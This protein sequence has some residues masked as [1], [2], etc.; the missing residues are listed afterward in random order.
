MQQIEITKTINILSQDEFIIKRPQFKATL[1]SEIGQKLFDLATNSQT[2]LEL[3]YFSKLTSS[4][5]V[6]AVVEK[7]KS[8]NINSLENREKQFF[9]ALVCDI[10]E[11]NGFV[12]SGKKSTVKGGMFSTGE[13][14]LEDK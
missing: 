6:Q 8:N 14:Y 7:L 10:L 5:A 2:V 13:V 4:P 11:N 3:I 12:K 9:G 1:E